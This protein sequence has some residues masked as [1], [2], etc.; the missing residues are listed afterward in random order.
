MRAMVEVP[1]DGA[2]ALRIERVQGEV[3]PEER[4]RPAQL[5]EIADAAVAAVTQARVARRER[6][7]D[8]ALALLKAGLSVEAIASRVGVSR[9]QV[10]MWAP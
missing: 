1:E 2:T 3:V 7:R 10:R 5:R 9:G 6:Q 8:E 4:L